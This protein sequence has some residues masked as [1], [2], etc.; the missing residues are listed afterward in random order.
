[1]RDSSSWL[2]VVLMCLGF[3]AAACS[4]NDAAVSPDVAT[5]NQDDEYRLGNGDLL[6]IT[7]FGQEDLSGEFEIDSGGQIVFPLVGD[8]LVVD[9]SPDDVEQMIVSALEAEYLKNPIVSIEVIE[10][11][12]CYIIREFTYRGGS[13]HCEPGMRVID[14]LTMCRG[15]YGGFT[16]RAVEDECVAIITRDGKR[17]CAGPEALLM[18]G[19][20]VEMRERF[21]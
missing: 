3:M 19:D 8:L 7:V 10:Y 17:K 21:F 20:I 2:L 12:P 1:M 9:R 11:R 14:L 5:V 16:Y 4:T 15:N 6:R 13:C 18:P